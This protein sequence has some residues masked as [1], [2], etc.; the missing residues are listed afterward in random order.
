MLIVNYNLLSQAFLTLAA[1]WESHSFLREPR[2]SWG[3]SDSLVVI[4]FI[5]PMGFC[6]LFFFQL[7]FEVSDVHSFS[8]SKALRFCFFWQNLLHYTI[9]FL[10][11]GIRISP[12]FTFQTHFTI[13]FCLLSQYESF[14]CFSSCLSIMWVHHQSQIVMK[15]RIAFLS[16]WSLHCIGLHPEAHKFPV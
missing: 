10:L 9:D 15:V 8:L 3:T 13:L 2:I 4:F 11:C 12:N 16:C 1:S 7:S 14:S 6:C 5:A